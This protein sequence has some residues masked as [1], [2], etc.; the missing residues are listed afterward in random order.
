M[1]DTG[2]KLAPKVKLETSISPELDKAINFM[3]ALSGTSKATIVREALSLYLVTVGA[4]L[5]GV[6]E[7]ITRTRTSGRGLAALRKDKK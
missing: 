1:T 4:M 2:P 6:T 5:P 7:P 3:V